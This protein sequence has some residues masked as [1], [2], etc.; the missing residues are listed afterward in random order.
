MEVQEISADDALAIC[1]RMESDFFDRKAFGLAPKKAQKIAVAFSNADGGEFVIGIADDRDQPAP[2]KRWSGAPE[3]EDFNDILQSLYSLNPSLD[4]KHDYL[5]TESFPGIVLRVFVSRSSSVCK[6]SDNTVYQRQGAAS[7]PIKDP[8]KITELSFAKG[9][10]SF[11]DSDLN[12]E[13]EV[14]VESEEATKFGSELLPPQNPL[15]YCVNQGL[16]RPNDF[17]PTCAGLLLFGDNPQAHFPRRCGTKIVFYDTKKEVPERDHLKKNISIGGCIYRQFHKAIE[18]IT[19]IM[20]SISVMTPAGLETIKYPPEA[21]W[22]VV[23]NAMIHRDYSISDDI[24]VTIFQNRIEVKSPGRLPG[25]VTKDNYLDVRYSRN[26]KIVQTLA[27]YKQPINKDLGEGLNTAFEKMRLWKLKS[28]ILEERDNYVVVTLPHTPLA[29]PEEGVMEY[30]KSHD[31][32]KNAVAREITGIR[33]ENQMK[34]VFYRLRDKKMIE[35]VPG[36]RGN[37]AAWRK[38]TGEGDISDVE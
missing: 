31:E 8:Q 1:T 19:F 7:N 20:S 10:A 27:R 14:V 4:F 16:I 18:E 24:Q 3:I 37:S 25:F 15:N 21:I 12:I 29:T 34:D 6:T 26:P 36:K 5:V 28:P 13:P 2:Q 35:R 17:G 9:A 23:A 38:Y 11:E 33:S 32:I 30:L 22:E